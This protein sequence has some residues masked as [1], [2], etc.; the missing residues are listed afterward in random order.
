[1]KWA[2]VLVGILV[3]SMCSNGV[4]VNTTTAEDVE[5]TTTSTSTSTSTTTTTTMILGGGGFP[6]TEAPPEDLYDLTGVWDAVFAQTLV[7]GDKHCK[8]SPVQQGIVQ[9]H[10]TGSTFTLSLEDGFDCRP[11]EACK[12]EGTVE[13]ECYLATNGGV[14]DTSEGTYTS[15]FVLCAD[16]SDPHKVDGAEGTGDATYWHPDFECGWVTELWITCRG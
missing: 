6:T 7:S 13:G 11:P 4:S 9:I 2:M 14:E 5:I 15:E 10:R 12:F 8:V 16:T 1:M 3:L